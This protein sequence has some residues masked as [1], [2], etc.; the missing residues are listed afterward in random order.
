MSCCRPAVPWLPG[1]WAVF[2]M[3]QSC[4]ERR[5]DCSNSELPPKPYSLTESGLR[6]RQNPS[7]NLNRRHID[8]QD[9]H[10]NKFGFLQT[11]SMLRSLVWSSSFCTLRAKRHCL[12]LVDLS[13]IFGRAEIVF[14]R[15]FSLL[16]LAIKDALIQLRT[17]RDRKSPGSAC[18]CA[19]INIIFFHTSSRHVNCIRAVILTHSPH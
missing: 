1:M 5:R 11:A 9:Y 6:L 10:L 8:C 3:S 18:L 4:T 7:T 19:G 17:P 2:L 15:F 14:K 16:R 13:E 12:L